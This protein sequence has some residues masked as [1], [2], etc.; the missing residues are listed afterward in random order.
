M[1]RPIELS[2]L[3]GALRLAHRELVALV[4]AGG[5]TTL[6]LAL[7]A[8]LPGPVVL[9]TTTR[10]GAD[11]T[12]G[13]PVVLGGLPEGDGPSIA[14]RAIEGPKAVGYRPEVVDG[15]FD[16]VDRLVVEA[17]GAR[18][19]PFKA[20]TLDEPRIPARATTVVTVAGADALGRV[21]E[22]QCHRPLRVAALAG[23]SSYQ[24]LTPKR[25]A[26]VL[27]HP[28]GGRKGAPAAARWVVAITKVDP[29]GAPLV[30]ELVDLLAPA[31]DT[32]VAV[33]STGG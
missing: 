13:F 2:R 33:A 9:T 31:A 3:A 28:E 18:G 27:L 10:M 20:P 11:Q 21:I 22:D 24:R 8:Q 1:A 16:R 7:G 6:L 14:W 29:A 17:D 26:R 32:V 5:K 15:W 12:G 19:L 25:A 23:C 30:E 4:G